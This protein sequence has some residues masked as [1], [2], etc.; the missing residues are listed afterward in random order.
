M[1]PDRTEKKKNVHTYAIRLIWDWIPKASSFSENEDKLM[2]FRGEWKEETLIKLQVQ[3][4]AQSVDSTN[5]ISHHVPCLTMLAT[6][7]QWGVRTQLL[8]CEYWRDGLGEDKW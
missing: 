1:I 4:L 5:S 8:P 6:A 3:C 7:K 2:G